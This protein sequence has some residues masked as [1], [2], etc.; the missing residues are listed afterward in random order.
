MKHKTIVNA[1]TAP[2]RTEG[3]HYEE[4]VR[5]GRHIPAY[6]LSG[7]QIDHD[8]KVV[9][10]AGG[11]QIG[12][13]ADPHD[14]RC[15]L[16]EILSE[17]VSAIR[18][19]RMRSPNERLISGHLGKIHRPHQ[20][21]HSADTDVNAMITLQNVCDLVCTKTLVVVGKHLKNEPLQLLVFPDTR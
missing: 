7:E 8:T 16:R 12:E 17:M 14:V 11:F 9:P 3:I 6:D 2:G 10:L 1:P 13:I 4:H 5:F 21:V 15:V 18:V 19:S 20:P